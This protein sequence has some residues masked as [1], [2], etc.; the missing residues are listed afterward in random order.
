MDE[1]SLT[2]P[3]SG[4]FLAQFEPSGVNE[5]IGDATQA[6]LIDIIYKPN[7]VRFDLNQPV[8]DGERYIVWGLRGGN[9]V[10]YPQAE[11]NCRFLT[12]KVNSLPMTERIFCGMTFGFRLQQQTLKMTAGHTSIQV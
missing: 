2:I 12:N 10:A 8:R 7:F 4:V 3:L 1:D 9:I 5:T 11:R 6:S